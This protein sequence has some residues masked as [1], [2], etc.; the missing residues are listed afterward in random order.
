MGE[1]EKGYLTPP[2]PPQKE[3]DTIFLIFIGQKI[4]G[5]VEEVHQRAELFRNQF[6][7]ANRLAKRQKRNDR[8]FGSEIRWDEVPSSQER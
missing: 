1:E 5:T 2:K 6:K 4:P 7:L 8:I 3:L